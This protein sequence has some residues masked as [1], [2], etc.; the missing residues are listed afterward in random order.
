MSHCATTMLI[1]FFTKQQE[2]Q[3]P[4]PAQ[5]QGQEEAQDAVHHSEEAQGAVD[6]DGNHSKG[7][8]LWRPW[9]GVCWAQ[10]T[11]GCRRVTTAV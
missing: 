3:D 8:V 5:A 6:R 11:P 10:T 9:W 7:A 4:A 1:P 2:F